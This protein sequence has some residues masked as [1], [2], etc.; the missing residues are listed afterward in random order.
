L[1]D[2]PGFFQALD[3]AQAGRWGQV[4]ALGH[5]LVGQA[6]VFLED[7]QDFSIGFIQLDF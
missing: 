2:Y 7:G 5:V 4:D 1:A 3:A 6:P